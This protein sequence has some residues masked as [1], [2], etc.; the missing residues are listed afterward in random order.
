MY[1]W[2]MWILKLKFSA[3]VISY[4]T[5]CMFCSFIRCASPNYYYYYYPQ[6]SKVEIDQKYLIW[7]YNPEPLLGC[8]EFLV[9]SSIV[10]HWF[11]TFLLSTF[12]NISHSGL[13]K[14]GT[15][16]SAFMFVTYWP[17]L[18]GQCSLLFSAR[19]S[20]FKP[21]S[22]NRKITLLIINKGTSNLVRDINFEQYIDD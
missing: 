7:S 21:N 8:S 10:Q 6:F 11:Y 17:T 4:D 2:Q 1:L 14:K 9:E 3:V 13:N 19:M 22:I 20:W 18:M 5:Y 15:D 16:F 12:F